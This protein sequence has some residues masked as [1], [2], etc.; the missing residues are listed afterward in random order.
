[1]H[2][3]LIVS[4]KSILLMLLMNKEIVTSFPGFGTFFTSFGGS[5][6]DSDSSKSGL[7]SVFTSFSPSGSS[8][9]LY[10]SS[11]GDNSPTSSVSTVASDKKT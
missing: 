5:K 9:G 8:D 10:S 4:L 11:S 3:L 7:G 1:M 2:P 6:P